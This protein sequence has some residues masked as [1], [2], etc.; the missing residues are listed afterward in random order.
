[1]QAPRIAPVAAPVRARSVITFAVVSREIEWVLHRCVPVCLPAYRLHP[2]C[3]PQDKGEVLSDV[4][5]II[6]EQLGTDVAEVR[7]F[8]AAGATAAGWLP[9]LPGKLT[10]LFPFSTCCRSR[11]SPS[12]LTWALTLWTP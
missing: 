11:P 12:L 6:S 1:M 4:C 9:A 8:A 2:V 3:P 7:R 10:P 5:K